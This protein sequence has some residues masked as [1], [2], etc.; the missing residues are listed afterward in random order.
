M[1]PPKPCQYVNIIGKPIMT[2]KNLEPSENE[3]AIVSEKYIEETLRLFNTYKH[4]YNMSDY[5][6]RVV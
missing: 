4:Q 1:G 3:L 2:Q 5:T 6:V